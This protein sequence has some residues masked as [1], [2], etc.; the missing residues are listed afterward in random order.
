MNGHK[1]RVLAFVGAAALAVMSLSGC[2]TDHSEKTETTEKTTAKEGFTP[3]L[4]TEQKVSLEVAGCLGNFEALDQVINDFNEYYPNVTITY[5]QNDLKALSEYVK[6]NN[7]VDIFM[8][9]D[10]NVRSKDQEAMYVYENCLDLSEQEIDTSAIEP[11]LVEAGTIDGKLVR[12]PLAK[13]MCGVV[14]N[15]TLLEKE[16][17]DVP[18]KYDE[19]LQVC[20]ALKSRGYT[21][22][23]SSKF[24]ACSDLVLPM[25]MSIVGNDSELMK[26]AETGDVSW[27]DG[28]TPVYE[29]L[30]ELVRKG[31]LSNE[32]NE[33][34]PDDNYDGA[35][36][37]FFEG[38]V[39]FWV[40]TTES[41]SGMKKRESKSET[42]S[43][44]PFEYEFIDAPLGD[45]GVYDYEEPWYG[46]SVNKD[47]D[48]LDYAVEFMKFLAQ[49]KELD[50]LAE[51][52]GM[53]SVTKDCSD[54]RF[55]DALNPE[56]EAGRYVYNGELG[57]TVTGAICDAANQ[58]GRG[59][60]SGA[61]GAVEM[62][63]SRVAQE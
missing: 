34:Y 39:P 40:T 45:E 13:L 44:E 63:K 26:K 6:N 1:T 33:T 50:K 51:V 41:F 14:V 32:V 16:G 24:H 29:K 35:I 42:F 61:D 18:Q 36:L 11:E 38:D 23:Q 62:I 17:L 30:E 52:K 46:F 4:D 43:A 56:R 25:A 22:I 53:P 7:Y 59:E 55:A 49:K 10:A 12:I 3:A 37:N 2:G 9:S 48:D 60:L 54:E 19:F 8:T 57:S 47:S 28:L 31:Y 58:L 5:E 21:P 15:K 27:A 20:E